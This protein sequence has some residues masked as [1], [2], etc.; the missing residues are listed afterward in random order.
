[1][2]GDFNFAAYL[3]LFLQLSISTPSFPVIPSQFRTQILGQFH[4]SDSS[5]GSFTLEQSFLKSSSD[6]STISKCLFTAEQYYKGTII[7]SAKNKT[8]EFNFSTCYLKSRNKDIGYQSY[9]IS[10]RDNLGFQL[11]DVLQL[12]QNTSEVSAVNITEEGTVYY[13]Q[14]SE[15]VPFTITALVLTEPAKLEKVVIEGDNWNVTLLYDQ[16]LPLTDTFYTVTSQQI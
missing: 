4:L 12:F 13:H 5:T 11:V 10:E 9:G 16:L 8:L 14:P 7:N 6:G 15:T 3:T 1:M 2:A